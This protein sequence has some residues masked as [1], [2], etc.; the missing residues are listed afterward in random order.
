[1]R[2][3]VL[4]ANREI[5][6]ENRSIPLPQEDECTVQIAYAGVCSS[7]IFRGYEDGAYFYPLV[8]G[9]ELAGEIV[10]LG[11]L[12]QE[13]KVGQK[14]SIFPLKPCF[15]CPSCLACN[16]AQ[17]H[18]YDYY[19]SRCDGGYSEFLNVKSWNILPI[20]EGVSLKDAALTEPVS[21]V[22]HA[23]R[24]AGLLSDLSINEQTQ[25]VA[26]IGA[27]FLGL[28]ALQILHHLHPQLKVTIFDRNAYKLAIANRLGGCTVTIK[29]SE[30]WVGYTNQKDDLFECV[31]E[32]SG[33]PENFARS[34]EIAKHSGKV[35]WMG[36][37]TGDLQISKILVSSAL[38]KEL[39]IIGTWNSSYRSN[40]EDDWLDAL[41]L[42]RSGIKPSDLVTHWV[43]LE[44][45]GEHIAKMHAHK[46][47]GQHFEHIKCVI[48]ND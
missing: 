3:A 24:R 22:L 16:Y 35:V 23:L 15:L 5:V 36:N 20:P 32:V 7:D 1:M 38:R 27:G 9:H 37:I 46:V 43:T 21:V 17:C 8:M 39:E 26:I 44:N 30:D 10:A 25:R 11:G 19:G 2:A 40:E 4:K 13:L 28:L 42:M 34:V 45:V 41:E 12:S 47:L 29:D 48:A 18:K 31:L 14:V 6:L 33:A